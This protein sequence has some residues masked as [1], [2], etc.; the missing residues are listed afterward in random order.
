MKKGKYLAPKE[1]DTGM[2]LLWCCGAV[3]LVGIL[4]L[5]AWLW[6]APGETDPALEA[7]STKATQAP[8]EKP[9]E[10][11][12]QPTQPEPPVEPEPQLTE[13]EQKALEM[14]AE[15][16][17][18]EK[19]WQLFFVTPE[20]L[21]GNSNVIY[22]RD[23]TKQKLEERPVGGIIYFDHNLLERSQV[24]NLIDGSQEYSKIDLF[25]AVDEEGGTVA[26]LGD[27]SGLA[28]KVGDMADVESVE[29]AREIGKTLGN[30]LKTLGFNVDFAPV[31]DV[32]TNPNNLV[33]KDRS[34]G[35]DA[36]D[37]A[38]KVAACV[39]GFREA[40]V[41][42]TLKHFPG[43]GD[44]GAD[45]HNGAVVSN[46]TLEELRACELL[47]FQAGI[48]A[49]AEFVMMG[50]I[51]LPNAI[52]EDL[53]ASLSKEIMTDLLRNEMGFKGI[54]ITDAMNMGAITDYYS[55][56]EA[57]VM[58]LKAGA[59]MI[60]M[61]AD[62]TAAYEGVLAEMQNDEQMRELIDEKVMRILAVKIEA[63][64]I[65]EEAE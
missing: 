38:E 42:C 28:T 49:G 43:H 3:L 60:L 13:A 54:I 14:M 22:A 21:T 40:G 52:T 65:T 19:V 17:D 24:Q 45:S 37:V 31:A 26:R 18:E 47:P 2:L 63:G 9:A 51:S 30:D 39:E 57:A 8:T 48:D 15:M 10:P 1:K 61:P 6:L 62:L 11:S 64:I 5:V 34:F 7:D 35:S 16:T 4:A 23:A 46:K 25:I 27:D 12:T 33:V 56:A 20:Q 36:Q 58:A 53:P 59:D 32:W 55:S 41:M 29:E 50:H 44:T